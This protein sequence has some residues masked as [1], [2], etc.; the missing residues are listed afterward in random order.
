MNVIRRLAVIAGV[1]ALGEVAACRS[2]AGPCDDAPTV[3]GTWHYVA[4]ED[5]PVAGSWSGTLTIGAQRCHDFEGVL[6]LVET[7]QGLSRRVAGP[8][9]GVFIDSTLARFDATL[10]SGPREH[11]ARF[12]NDSMSGTWV[13]L[14]SASAATGHVGGRRDPGR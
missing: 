8:V 11:L 4:T 13:E 5:A 6:D 3:T 14:E 12:A 10:G 9:S 2:A 7:S 1:A